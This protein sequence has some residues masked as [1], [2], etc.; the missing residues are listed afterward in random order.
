M[1]LVSRIKYRWLRFRV[2]MN[3]RAVKMTEN[4]DGLT[5]EQTKIIQIC[6]KLITDPNSKLYAS[7]TVERYLIENDHVF[8]RITSNRVRVINGKY[9]YDMTFDQHDHEFIGIKKLF[10][11]NLEYRQDKLES[12]INQRVEKSLDHILREINSL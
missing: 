3:R 7:I 6:K 1:R 11:K 5:T 4:T 8:A 12:H 10:V 9:K 2:W